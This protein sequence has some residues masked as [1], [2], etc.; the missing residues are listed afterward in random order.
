M[1]VTAD[2]ITNAVL[3]ILAE[4]PGL[5]VLE[6]LT[7]CRKRGITS[8]QSGLYKELKKLID[9]GIVF[10]VGT[11]FRLHMNW[12]LELLNLSQT[13]KT[14]YLEGSP[15]IPELPHEGAKVKWKLTNLYRLN[16]LFTNVVLTLVRQSSSKLHLSWNPHPWFHLLQS[17]QEVL[18]FRALRS[19]SVRMY[20]IVGSATPLD[21]WSEQFWDPEMVVWSY[22]PSP[23]HSQRGSYFS[24]VDDFIVTVELNARTVRRLDTLY[25]GASDPAPKR[26]GD[27]SVAQLLDPRVITL[28]FDERAP[29]TLTLSRQAKK[30]Q[31]IRRQ[32]ADYF[33]RLVPGTE[34]LKR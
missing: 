15:F 2:P 25:G 5:T 7:A 32:Y 23:F 26:G 9:A 3:C 24:V 14:H 28:L 31:Q 13:V 1:N 17:Q 20:K 12:V 30:A 11:S 29:A 16:D 10:K 4:R 22:A 27:T 19:F 18:F 34:R 33:G 6:L 21:R 8:S